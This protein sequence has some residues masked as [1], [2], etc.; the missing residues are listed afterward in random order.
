MKRCDILGAQR[1]RRITGRL[2]LG[3]AA[4]LVA[5]CADGG[6]ETSQRVATANPDLIELSDAFTGDFALVDQDGGART[7]EDFKGRIQFIYFGFATCPDVCPMAL[8][9]MTAAL[10]ALEE[11]N[12]GALNE[13]A[14]LFITVDPERDTPAALKAYLAFDPRIAG[15]SGSPAAAAAARD[16][17]KVYAKKVPLEDSALGYTMD[18]S[19]LFYLTD[20]K[21]APLYAIKDTADPAS[22]ASAISNLLN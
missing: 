15:L 13:I 2:V 19:S 3:L 14:P 4:A 16:G 9:R 21:G 7:D 11:K 20:R 18:H 12:A 10:D 22:I 8:G 1:R 5:S 17:F 6:G